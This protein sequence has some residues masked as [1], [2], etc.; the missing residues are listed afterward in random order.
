MSFVYWCGDGAKL[1][2]RPCG[3]RPRRKGTTARRSMTA[4]RWWRPVSRKISNKK[5]EVTTA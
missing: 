5:A 4:K 2:N 3:D 1:L